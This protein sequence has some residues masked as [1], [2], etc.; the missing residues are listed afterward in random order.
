LSSLTIVFAYVLD[1][2]LGDPQWFPHPVRLMGKIISG[3]QGLLRKVGSSPSW[4]RFAGVLLAAILCGVAYLATILLIHWATGLSW[5][6]G[7]VCSSLLAY[8]TLATRDLHAE[9]RKV[10]RALEAGDLMQARRELS[11]LVGRDTESLEEPEI[12]RALVETVAEN[13]SDGVIAPLFYLALGGPAWAMTYKAI[14]T[15]DSMIGYKDE[16]Y[17]HIGWASAR[18]DDA[19]NFL[20]ARL[21]GFLITLSSSILGGP[22]GDSLRILLRDH[23][24]HPSPNSAWPEA[25]IAG[26]LGVQLGGL[27]YYFGQPGQKPLIGDRNKAIERRDVKKAWKILYL[28]SFLMLLLALGL[29]RMAT[30]ILPLH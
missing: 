8:T 27:N 17:R 26:A 25:A 3:L 20:P 15:L 4:L 30:S 1:L 16:K 12:L 10:L 5:M 9:S 22:W 14:N 11:F 13:I 28:S 23:A 2:I 19:A 7:M 21:S 29:S 24:R 18:L 6:A